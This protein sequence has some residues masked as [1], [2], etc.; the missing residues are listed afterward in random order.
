MN[1]SITHNRRAALDLWHAYQA[2]CPD[3]TYPGELP[4]IDHF[5]DS[6][7]LADEL[8]ELVLDGT[9]RAIATLLVDLLADGEPLPCIGGH[10]IACDG[11]GEP[12]AILRTT[13]LRIGRADSVDE[14]FAR[15]EGE[16]DRNGWLQGHRRYWKR[17]QV[18][19]GSDWNEDLE[20]VF[21][22]FDV[23]WQA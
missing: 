18:S 12:R 4:V 8:L 5:G 19:R 17:E 22:R 9:K 3:R 6:P 23:V 13:E 10:W 11:R 14:A 7:E 15:E 2:A 1:S 20:V 21:E 16:P